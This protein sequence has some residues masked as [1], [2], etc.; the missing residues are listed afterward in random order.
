MVGL[1]APAGEIDPESGLESTHSVTTAGIPSPCFPPQL[2][3]DSTPGNFVSAGIDLTSVSQVRQSLRDF[4][5]R[6]LHRVFTPTEI[7]D[8][9]SSHDPA[10]H[11]AARFAAKEATIKALMVEDAHPHWTSIEVRRHPSGWCGIRLSDRAAQL[12]QAKGIGK[13]AVSLSHEGDLAAAIV[14]ATTGP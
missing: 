13:F 12:A 4:G 7:A 10:P 11:L 1:T 8:C 5:D 9:C 14:V 3:I 2:P 6:Y